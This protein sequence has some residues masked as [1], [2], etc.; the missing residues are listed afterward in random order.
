VFA[1]A[2][3][4]LNRSARRVPLLASYFVIGL[5]AGIALLTVD[6]VGYSALFDFTIAAMLGT[7]LL[8]QHLGERLAARPIVL[9]LL[10]LLPALPV[11]SLG[12]NAFSPQDGLRA[13]LARAANWQQ[14]IALIAAAKGEVAC[15][16]L[17]LCY[18]AGRDSAI[19]FFN[20]GQYARLH[21]EFADPMLGQIQAG[22]LSMVQE[23]GSTGSGRLPTALNTAIAEHYRPE[24]SD[25]TTLL[26]PRADPSGHDQPD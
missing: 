17:S 22:G 9:T 20:F 24:Q 7:A 11:L 23:D 14:S 6:G 4:V 21:P 5:V 15:E 8:V 16:M 18:W 1:I 26:V 19:E 13:D 10:R 3:M 2:G 12:A 25:P